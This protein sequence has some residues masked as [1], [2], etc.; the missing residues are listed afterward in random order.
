MKYRL[1]RTNRC[2]PQ[3]YA[4][5]CFGSLRYRYI[6]IGLTLGYRF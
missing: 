2:A 4:T 1:L 5:V 3:K 6:S